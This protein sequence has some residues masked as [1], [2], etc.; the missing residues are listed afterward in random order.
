[1]LWL[2]VGTAHRSP[3]RGSS[4]RQKGTIG[5][6]WRTAIVVKK[7]KIGRMKFVYYVRQPT[8]LPPIIVYMNYWIKVDR[9]RGRGGS[10]LVLGTVV[11]S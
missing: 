6:F 7:E 10:I 9:T 5:L 8:G 11:E 4:W 3:S 1:M 2:I